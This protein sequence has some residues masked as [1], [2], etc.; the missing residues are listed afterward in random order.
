MTQQKIIDE[1]DKISDHLSNLRLSDP[2]KERIEDEIKA[3]NELVRNLYSKVISLNTLDDRQCKLVRNEF[4]DVTNKVQH[5]F[6]YES[7]LEQYQSLSEFGYSVDE[8]EALLKSDIRDLMQQL[9][10]IFYNMPSGVSDTAINLTINRRIM[11]D[12]SYYPS[13]PLESA[14]ETLNENLDERLASTLTLAIAYG[15]DCDLDCMVRVKNAKEIVKRVMTNSGF[16]S[17]VQIIEHIK[18]PSEIVDGLSFRA[19]ELANAH[20]KES[21]SRDDNKL[22]FPWDSAKFCIR[23]NI[24]SF[25]ISKNTLLKMAMIGST[26]YRTYDI[27]EVIFMLMLKYIVAENKMK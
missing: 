14:N 20:I 13:Y 8:I 1:L 9:E 16:A 6:N 7:L 10:D 3:C 17:Q 12:H 25:R 26:K 18:Y 11:S 4:R 5:V 24:D 22:S 2:D 19:L 27:H 15:L 21:T 23:Q